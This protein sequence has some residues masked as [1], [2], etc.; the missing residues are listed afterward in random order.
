MYACSFAKSCLT[1]CNPVE[2]S[3]PGSSVHEIFHGVGYWSGLP[4]PPSGCMYTYGW[5]TLYGRNQDNTVK[6]LSSN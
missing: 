5:F 4:F 6:Q 1:L 2:C 3:P